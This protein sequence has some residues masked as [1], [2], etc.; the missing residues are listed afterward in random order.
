MRCLVID[1]DR[2]Q[3]EL[4]GSF[5]QETEF[6]TLSQTCESAVSAAN[7]LNHITV[8]LILLDIEMPVMSGLEFMRI[9]N[10]SPQII[11]ATSKEKY[12]VEAFNY[13]VTDYLLKPISYSRFLKAVNKAKYQFD[14]QRDANLERNEIFVKVNSVV[15]KI[16]L[17]DIL[18][19]EAAV[20][21][22]N[23]R[24]LETRYMVNTS[25]S[26]ILERLPQKDFMRIHRSYIVRIDKIDS[27]DGNTILIGDQLIRIGRSYRKLF[28]QRISPI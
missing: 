1:D 16:I 28:M 6:L 5:V 22:V 27:I 19:I 23:I 14:Q 26:S 11:L 25:L 2:T 21:Y 15:E 17:P 20:D 3:R 13:D 24:T 10:I 8:D 4:L 9:I 18:L 12:A 7:L